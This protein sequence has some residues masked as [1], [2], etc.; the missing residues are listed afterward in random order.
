MQ[1]KDANGGVARI[2]CGGCTFLP[3][4]VDDLF[5]V[6]LNTQQTK[7]TKLTAPTLQLSPPS[8][9]VRKKL[10]SCSDAGV[11]LQLTPINYAPDFLS[12]PGCTCTAPPG[13]D[14]GSK[15]QSFLN[16]LSDCVVFLVL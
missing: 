15:S 16:L 11:H 13:Y 12:A 1:R 14:Y 3:Q 4:K 10:T 2:F 7:T 5:I 9:K 6:V 8:K